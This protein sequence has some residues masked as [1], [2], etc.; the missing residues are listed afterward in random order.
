[1]RPTT[2]PSP[3]RN[4]APARPTAAPSSSDSP[5]TD[6]P[7]HIPVRRHRKRNAPEKTRPSHRCAAGPVPLV[8]RAASLFRSI[9]FT[10]TSDLSSA[11]ISQHPETQHTN[12]NSERIGV[13]VFGFFSRFCPPLSSS[14][15]IQ[16][17]ATQHINF[18]QR[19]IGVAI[20]P[21]RQSTS[22]NHTATDTAARTPKRH[23]CKE[24]ESGKVARNCRKRKNFRPVS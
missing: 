16:L 11:Q 20:R 23:G 22:S 2:R 12:Q 14:I 24:P 19:R 8:P 5:P 1:M 15:S 7:R 6:P 4:S 18:Q 17:T 13:A 10:R 3:P 21:E 9:T